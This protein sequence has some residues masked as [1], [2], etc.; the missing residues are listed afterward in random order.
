MVL[1]MPVLAT[2]PDAACCN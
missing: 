2:Y 1:Y